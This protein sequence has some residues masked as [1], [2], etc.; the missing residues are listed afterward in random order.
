MTVNPIGRTT[1]DK[2][3]VSVSAAFSS[4]YY[5]TSYSGVSGKI[6][7]WVIGASAA[8]AFDDSTAI[9]GSVAYLARSA[10]RASTVKA[11]SGFLFSIGAR[12]YVYDRGLTAIVL[13]GL[14]HILDDRY[15]YSG[16]QY[17]KMLLF[18][19]TGGALATYAF[20]PSITAY[21]GGE[22]IAYSDGNIQA[23]RR[24]DIERARSGTLRGGA[25]FD[26]NWYWIRTELALCSETA[27]VVGVGQNF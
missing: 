2:T 20:H 11:G 24:N 15:G 26:M 8:Q 4:I 14:G 25:V 10:P 22:V 6:D 18:E 23:G 5:A 16:P 9:C 3:E 21:A 13:Y 17:Q 1:G 19:I 7:R 12:K 27:L